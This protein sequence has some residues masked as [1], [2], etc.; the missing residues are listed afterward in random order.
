M[1][2]NDLAGKL[3][4]HG[5]GGPCGRLGNMGSGTLAGAVESR[6]PFRPGAGQMPPYLAGREAELAFADWRLGQLAGG[7]APAQG[8]L[9]YG[10]RGNGKTVL[11]EH[12]AAR[13][14]DLGLRAE[15]LPPGALRSEGRLVRSLRQRARLTGGRLTGVQLG[16]LGATAERAEPSTDASDLFEAWI[17]AD[18]APLV[19]V[20]D[21]AH[22]VG[23][24]V[25]RNFFDAVQNASSAG[26]PFF[27]I[28]A[29]TPDAP[30]KI[31]HAGTFAERA[32]ERLPIGRLDRAAATQALVKPAEAGGRPIA[33]N[34][35]KLLV[36]ESQDYPYF[37]QLLGQAAWEAA[38][39]ADESIIS[40]RTAE[41]AVAAAR[42]SVE[43]LFM[44]RFE[45][46]W[47]HEIVT[48]LAPLADRMV[49]RDGRLGDHEFRELLGEIAG[50]ESVPFDSAS[51]LLTLRDLGV[52]WETAS[53]VWEMGI[54]SFA[55]YTL[56]RRG[57][58]GRALR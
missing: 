51:L 33:G 32:L 49:R 46:A 41:K 13:A 40:V 14:G 9:L 12:I 5:S 53:G 22:T 24:A 43:Q 25:G 17:R 42:T 18:S 34:A 55:D 39:D 54:P 11:L 20:V 37:I 29:G 48:A 56:R 38:D 26:L 6:N 21:E 35:L 19:V 28:A 47:E 31:R 10:P 36:G 7:T 52:V 15:R 3:L 4:S 44:G 58:T 1:Q 27:L 2:G 30:R 8:L 50:L 57:G 23:P 16:P 45:E